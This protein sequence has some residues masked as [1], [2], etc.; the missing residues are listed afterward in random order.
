M[1]LCCPGYSPL[2]VGLPAKFACPSAK[3]WL[4]P[5]HTQLLPCW[6]MIRMML[7]S[8]SRPRGSAGTTLGP[9]KMS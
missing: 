2:Q 4:P 7:Q 1:A 6:T 8:F 3:P 9:L 5:N